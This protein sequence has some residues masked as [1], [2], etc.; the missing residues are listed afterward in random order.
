MN[1]INTKECIFSFVILVDIVMV[2]IV[3]FLSVVTA[4]ITD[5]QIYIIG[6]V[7]QTASVSTNRLFISTRFLKIVNK[8]L[9]TD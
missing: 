8:L 2:I 3:V 4:T 9:H 6:S 5:T 1:I 7:V